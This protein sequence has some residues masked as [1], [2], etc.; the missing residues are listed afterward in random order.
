MSSLVHAGLAAKGVLGA[1]AM[2]GLQGT[3]LAL[4]A[5]LV[6]MVARPA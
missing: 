5:I 2:M 4:A 1:L 3:I 6:L